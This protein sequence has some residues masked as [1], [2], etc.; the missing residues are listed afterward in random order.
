M[1]GDVDK[2]L[3]ECRAKAGSVRDKEFGITR[4]PFGLKKLAGEPAG[5]GEH[6]CPRLEFASSIPRPP[7]APPLLSPSFKKPSFA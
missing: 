7:A 4:A 1:K 2:A 6:V 5:E 3:H